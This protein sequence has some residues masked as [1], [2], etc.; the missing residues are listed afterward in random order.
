ML[1]REIELTFDSEICPCTDSNQILSFLRAAR[2]KL[3]VSP[4]AVSSTSS[5]SI[6]YS[7]TIVFVA[8]SSMYIFPDKSG[9]TL[10]VCRDL[11]AEE[12][13]TRQLCQQLPQRHM[14]PPALHKTVC[15]VEARF[16]MTAVGIHN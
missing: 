12:V 10:D 7:F 13:R 1:E 14:P 8:A 4:R 11:R 2:H 3:S 6:D 16:K 9:A 5:L 15:V